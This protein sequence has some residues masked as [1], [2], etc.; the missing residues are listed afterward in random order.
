MRA[1]L[2]VREKGEEVIEWLVVS[3]WWLEKAE[4]GKLRAEC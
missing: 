3:S 2:P 4:G 1:R